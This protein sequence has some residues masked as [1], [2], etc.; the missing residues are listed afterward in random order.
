MTAKYFAI[1]TNYGAAQLAN[2][3]ALGTKL[4][5]STMAVGD[6]GGVLPVPDPAQTKL[7]RET[8]RAAINQLSVDEKNAN[9]IVAEQ[10]IPENEGGWFIRE[11]GL[12]DDKGGLI[13]VGNAP[14]TYK[15][16]LQEG[17]GRTQVIQ[18]VLMVSSTDAITLKVD[19][20]VVLATRDFVTK[21]VAAAIQESETRAAQ[22]Y[23]QKGDYVLSPFF[24]LEMLKKLDK[25]DVVNQ[26]GNDTGKAA[27]QHL[28]T[29]ELGKKASTADVNGKFDKTGGEISGDVRIKADGRGLL[30]SAPMEDSASYMEFLAADKRIAYIGFGSNGTKQLTLSN[31]KTNVTL[32]IGEKVTVNG[33]PVLL[34]SDATPVGVF[35]HFPHRAAQLPSKWY[36]VN[37]DRFS[38]TSPQGKVLKALPQEFK[39][40]WGITESAGMINVPNLKQPDGRVPFLR[41]INGTSRQVGT[42]IGDKMRNL[43]GGMYFRNRYMGGG[44]SPEIFWPIDGE[45]SVFGSKEYQITAGPLSTYSGTDLQKTSTLEFNAA[46]QVDTG[47]EFKP[48]DIGVTV[49]IYL[50]V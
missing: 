31:T 46:N 22:T 43:S 39:S 49:A 18:M 26:L 47:P 5:I 7:I 41:G 12:F 11:I 33:V 50:G 2:A 14:E 44:G 17:S 21:S 30:F 8:R 35:S 27:S 42:V 4:S 38:V 23:Q 40:D 28:L 6:G 3:V 24:K 34:E 9:Y 1:L 36:S 13:A 20:T 25:A 45:K 16:N 19:P 37:G 32:Q 10:V 48:L 15:P 29:T